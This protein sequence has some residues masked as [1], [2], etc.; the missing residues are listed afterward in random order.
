MRQV[1][2]RDRTSN[3]PPNREDLPMALGTAE[4]EAEGSR[5]SHH[6]DRNG[7]GA[8]PVTDWP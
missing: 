7:D 3:D 5:S 4:K 6:R 2:H 8:E 1:T